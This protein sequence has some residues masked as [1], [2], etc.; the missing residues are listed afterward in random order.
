MH[1]RHTGQVADST[2][3]HAGSQVRQDG[4]IHMEARRVRCGRCCDQQE[5]PATRFPTHM[6][7][8]YNTQTAQGQ[9][10]GVLRW[11]RAHQRGGCA[12]QHRLHAVQHQH[13][14]RG[15]RGIHPGQEDT[16]RDSPWQRTQEH[17]DNAGHG[18]LERRTAGGGDGTPQEPCHELAGHGLRREDGVR[19]AGG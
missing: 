4:D 7:R 11:T 10:P 9:P 16:G 13:T 6:Q 19:T 5:V 8:G 14:D 18:Q 12:T 1:D 17:D 15:R 3:K 2:T